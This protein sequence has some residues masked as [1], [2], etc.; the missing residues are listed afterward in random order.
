MA[1]VA[2][3]FLVG[4][5]IKEEMISRQRPKP[6]FIT[7]SR[8]SGSGGK[9]IARKLAEKLRFKLYDEQLIGLVAKAARK[10]KSVIAR[11]DEKERTFVDDVIHRLLN[12]EY[13]SS[14]TYIKSLCQTIKALSLKGR[15]VIL[16]R[17]A[18]F[19]TSR[20]D[21]LHVR[22]IAPY[23]VRVGFT[24]RYEKRKEKEARKK[25]KKHDWARKVFVKQYFH[26]NPS[27]TN[28]YDL[29]VNTE[30]LTVDQ[31]VGVIIR[32]FKQKLKD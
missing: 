32:A 5:N 23:L 15:V 27:N 4:Y 28:Y 8:E 2:C 3:P 12:P 9:I 18:N 31:V 30:R 29:V 20:K 19:I 24:M 22:V 10:R 26:K 16:G 6:F 17:G 1:A 25:V 14:Q 21:G 13:V 7:I 11:L